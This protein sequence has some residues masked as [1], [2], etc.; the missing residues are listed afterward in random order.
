MLFSKRIYWT[1][2][3]AYLLLVEGGKLAVDVLKHV[4]EVEGKSVNGKRN[5]P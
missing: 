4:W 2:R 3:V 1:S 5:H